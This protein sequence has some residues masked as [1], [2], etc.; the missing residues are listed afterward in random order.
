MKVLKNISGNT[1][2]MGLSFSGDSVQTLSSAFVQLKVKFTT[3]GK[4]SLEIG[5]VNAYDI[6]RNKVEIVGTSCPIDVY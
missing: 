1:F 3:K 4:Y 5:S 6:K 2:D